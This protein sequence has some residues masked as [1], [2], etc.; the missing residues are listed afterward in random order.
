MSLLDPCPL[1]LPMSFLVN[2]VR[3]P[4]LG[5]PFPRPT[6]S[7]GLLVDQHWITDKSFIENCLNPVWTCCLVT[8]MD[9]ALRFPIRIVRPNIWW[10]EVLA[11]HGCLVSKPLQSRLQTV[12]GSLAVPL[13]TVRTVWRPFTQFQGLLLQEATPQ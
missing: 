12:V 11:C 4:I 6:I 5:L 13:D 1:P 2:R 3:L 7:W 10:I 9:L 8:A